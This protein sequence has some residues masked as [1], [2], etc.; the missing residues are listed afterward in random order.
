MR[1]LVLVLV[2]CT[3]TDTDSDEV[4]FC[5]DKPVLTYENFGQG[6]LLQYCQTCH[7][8]SVTGEDRHNAPES[9]HFDTEADVAA[10][11]ASVLNLA[12]GPDP[13]M[14][15]GGGVPDLDREKLEIWL[16]CY[17]PE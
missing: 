15:P 6:F 4:D 8:S 11:L 14:P 5:A 1:W 16:R 2:G 10:Q 17:P 12:T 13:F 3:K 7:G 9:V